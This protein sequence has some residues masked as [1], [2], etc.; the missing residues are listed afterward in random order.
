MPEPEDDSVRTLKYCSSGWPSEKGHSSTPLI[1]TKADGSE[2]SSDAEPQ[3]SWQSSWHSASTCT[4]SWPCPNCCLCSA[5]HFSSFPSFSAVTCWSH[6]LLRP[7]G[8]ELLVLQKLHLPHGPL[9]AE[10]DA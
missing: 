9:Q 8:P 4:T 5:R 7:K 10:H 3:T 1:T 6:S 2:K